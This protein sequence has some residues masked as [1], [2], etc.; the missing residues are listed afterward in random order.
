MSAT[1]ERDVTTP[2]PIIELFEVGTIMRRKPSAR[3]GGKDLRVAVKMATAS[4]HPEPAVDVREYLTA[5]TD[6][7]SR[8]YAGPTK[9][10]L[11]LSVFDAER[12]S[13]LLADAV[14]AAET[15]IEAH[16]AEGEEER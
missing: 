11:W 13:E 15:W 3:H 14:M 16:A 7:R 10:G 1:T 9:V 6:I 2:P 5:S 4:D 12:L 8:A